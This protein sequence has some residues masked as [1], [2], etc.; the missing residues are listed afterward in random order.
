MK[1]TCLKCGEE[2]YAVFHPEQKDSAHCQA[3]LSTRPPYSKRTIEHL[4][5]YCRCGFDW[6]TEPVKVPVVPHPGP[7]LAPIVPAPSPSMKDVVNKLSGVLKDFCGESKGCITLRHT[8]HGNIR[9]LLQ[10]GGFNDIELG[11]RQEQ[12]WELIRKKMT[13]EERVR[14]SSVFTLGTNDAVPDDFE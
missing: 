13:P 9:A 6:V 7:A 14:I 5:F 4:H 8:P 12:I 11:I 1:S 3:M 2:T 10:W